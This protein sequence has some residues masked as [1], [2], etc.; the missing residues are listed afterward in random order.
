MSEF[1]DFNSGIL[2]YLSQFILYLVVF[3]F[4][5]FIFL[6]FLYIRLFGKRSQHVKSIGIFH[7]YSNA[8]GG[9]ERVLWST[10][11]AIQT[12]HP[13]YVLF[14][15]TGDTATALEQTERA[16]ER[17]GIEFPHPERI[18]RVPLHRRHLV[19]PQRYPVFTLL[20]Q[21]IGS[22]VL[23][24][25]ALLKH[26]PDVFIDTVG[27]AFTYPLARLAGRCSVAA[28][29]H[30]P[31]IST[32][33]LAAVVSR[34]VAVHNTSR[35][36]SSAIRSY[37]KL[38]YYGIFAAAYGLC[39]R[40]ANVVAVNSSWTQNHIQRLWHRP[41]HVVYPP[42]PVENLIHIPLKKR[43]P[44]IVSIAQFRPEKRHEVTVRSFARMLSQH[45]EHSHARL[46]LIGGCRD[47]ADAQRV[48]EIRS[49]VRSLGVQDRVEFY[50]NAPMDRV[51]ELLSKATVGVNTMMNEHFGIV[52]VEYMA[53]GVVPI[54][55]NSAGPR[56]DIITRSTG[57]L[58]EDD[59]QFADAFHSALAMR[60]DDPDRFLQMQHQAR[61]SV[62]RFSEDAFQHHI[63]NALDVILS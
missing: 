25:E 1:L 45:P 35:V 43:D 49:F 34:Q 51:H 5:P 9:G 57:F 36:A 17:F 42:C 11:R 47:S 38:L 50:V 23:A 27:Y 55:H 44:I 3:F 53:A 39:G 29:V 14:L 30:Y 18:H 52:F 33:M 61:R 40:G 58:A 48:N 24:A 31:T 6:F 54:G 4:S 16:T 28:Y 15:Y 8:G 2:Y 56:M 46:I 26:T 37:V 60:R 59:Q 21:S 10:I 20:G 32:D 63:L 12:Q 13:D 7:P 41:V 19:E 22:V 62:D